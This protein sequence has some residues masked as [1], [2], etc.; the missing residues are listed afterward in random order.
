MSVRSNCHYVPHWNVDHKGDCPLFCTMCYWKLKVPLHYLMWIVVWWWM[1][2]FWIGVTVTVKLRHICEQNVVHKMFSFQPSTKLYT[3]G[4]IAWQKLLHSFDVLEVKT[5][6]MKT[7]PC[8][9]LWDT[10]L[11]GKSAYT[12]MWALVNS[13]EYIAFPVTLLLLMFCTCSAPL[14]FLCT[15]LKMVQYGTL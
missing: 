11:H 1:Q 6:I 13:T 2:I 15:L 12:C 10:S 7:P 9:W 5:I 3:V 4:M 8:L 14:K